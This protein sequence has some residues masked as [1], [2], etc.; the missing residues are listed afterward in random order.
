[1]VTVKI[2]E[3][4]ELGVIYNQN[5]NKKTVSD[6]YEIQL[7]NSAGILRSFFTTQKTYQ[8]S[9]SHLPNGLYFVHIIQGDKIVYRKQFLKN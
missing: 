7:W 4:T 6:N 9:V 8:F 2:P 1:L 3:D 5:D